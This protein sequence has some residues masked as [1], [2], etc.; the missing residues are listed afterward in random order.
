MS[1]PK[2]DVRT[3]L[4]H[5]VHAAMRILAGLA[6]LTVERYAEKVI[7]KH[8]VGE[9]KAA[10]VRADEFQRAGIDRSFRESGF[11]DGVEGGS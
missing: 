6:G 1:L 7:T 9:A 3:A 8:V 5:Q 2:K 4:P 11:S 10:I